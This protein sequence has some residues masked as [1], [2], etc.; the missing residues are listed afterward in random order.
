[1]MQELGRQLKEQ[2]IHPR[3]L[4]ASSGSLGTFS[5]MWLGAKYF[6]VG[7][8]VV[9]VAVSYPL[10]PPAARCLRQT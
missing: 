2:D 9:P 10:R 5:G 4:V 1:M 8:E 7:L 3:Y 6:N